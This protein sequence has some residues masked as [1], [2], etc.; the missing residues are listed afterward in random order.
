MD[1]LNNSPLNAN[2]LLACYSTMLIQGYEGRRKANRC[3]IVLAAKLLDYR[4]RYV[5]R[6]NE[7]MEHEQGFLG[8]SCT[9]SQLEDSMT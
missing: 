4:Y 5:F 7:P 1:E 8:H 3:S 6:E 9:S 2:S